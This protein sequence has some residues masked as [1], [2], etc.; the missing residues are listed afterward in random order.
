MFSRKIKSVFCALAVAASALN[1]VSLDAIAADYVPA[2]SR[3][4]VHDPSVIKDPK[5]GTYYVFGSHI[6]AAKSGDLQS[7]RLFT[8]GYAASGNQLFGNLSGN[9]QK[10]FAWCGEN[11]EDCAGG[12]AVWAPD[13][14]WNPEYINSDGTR[15]AYVM[16]FCTSST[17]IR[18]V[19]AYAVSENIEGPYTFVDTLIYSGFTE[20]DQYVTSNTKNVNKKYTSTNIDE[21]IAAGEV[22]MNNSWFNKSNYNNQLF[23]NAIDPTIYYGT[24]GKMYMCYGSWSGGIFTLEI[25]PKTGKCIHPKTGTTADGRMIDSYFGTK[26]SGGYGKSGEGPFIEFNEKTGFYYL[27]VTYGGLTSAGGYNMRVGRSK[28]PTGPFVDAAGRNMVLESGTNL[29]SIGLKVMTN[30]KFS[31]LARAYM[32][33]GHNSVLR[34]DDGQWYLL[35]HARFDDGSEYHEVRVHAMNFNEAGWPV[36]MPYEYSGESWSAA[37]FEPAALAGTY[38]FINHGTATDGNITTASKITLNQDG[39]ISGAV[40]GTWSEANDSAAATLKIGNTTYTGFFNPQFDESGKGNKVMTFTAAGS[41]NQTV[42]GVKTD[43]WNGSERNLLYNHLGSGQLIYDQNAVADIRGS[44]YISG[45]DLLSNLPYTITNVNSGL[46]LDVAKSSTEDGTP[47]QQWAKRGNKSGDA[48]QDF[49][50]TDLG[51]GYCRLTS[52]LDE[53]KCIAVNGNSAEN[54]LDIQLQTY[55]GADNQQWKLIKSGNYFGIVSRCSGDE[56][57]MDVYEWSKENGG[58]IKQWEFWGGE[59]QLWKVTPTFAAVPEYSYTVR[60]LNSGLFV[61]AENGSLLQNTAQTAWNFLK[62]DSGYYI[63]T[64]GNGQAVTVSGAEDG[65]DLRLSEYTG[66]ENQQFTLWCNSDGSYAILS[67]LTG[68]KAGF[69]VYEVSK[70]NGAKICQWSFRGG[71]GQKFILSPAE[72]P[73]PDIFE[74]TAETTETTSAGESRLLGDT[75]CN[76]EVNVLDAV[77]LARVIAEDV[78]SGVTEQGKLNS[79]CN[80]S[81][82]PDPGDLTTLLKHLANLINIHE[83][84]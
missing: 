43:T 13:V 42:W 84:T 83:D 54:A 15:G 50:I 20:N 55:T 7:W 57:A 18:S 47:I 48:N 65:A 66:A 80:R 12:F 70:E 64:N 41:D 82:N 79:D 37:G 52:M 49:R 69:D 16:Y 38:E 60:S 5:T 4:S 77:L 1:A 14:I 45:T 44:V 22:T 56:G 74:T 58:A 17:Y 71:D 73:L 63:I 19:I 59:C 61:S 34:D 30:Y 3:V 75:D 23:P 81:G 51:N 11:L 21:L 8:N 32:A 78:H 62:T 40:T 36:V 76:G 46:V 25:D 29:N 9:L 28:N 35:N 67:R 31:G 27:W 39:T 10:A 6:D 53:T 33:C 68:E 26:I 24:D 72:K 2:K